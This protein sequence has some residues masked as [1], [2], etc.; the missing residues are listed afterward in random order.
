MRTQISG[1][2]GITHVYLE[3][4]IR[5]IAG[6]K[7]FALT[8]AWEAGTVWRYTLS[9]VS[10][11]TRNSR[12]GYGRIL[13]ADHQAATPRGGA[14]RRGGLSRQCRAWPIRCPGTR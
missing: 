13:T 11:T 6:I 3:S 1:N 8:V 7:S 12:A 10:D 4:C 9:L 5:F 2:F 14:P